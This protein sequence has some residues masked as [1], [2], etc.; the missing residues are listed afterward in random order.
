MGNN[1]PY[2]NMKRLSID[3]EFDC[4]TN[5]KRMNWFLDRNLAVV[6]DDDTYQLTFITKGN[7]NA[8]RSDFYK[9]PL[10]NICVECGT[11]DDL[12]K[13]H[14]VPSQYRK[15]LPIEYKSRSSFDIVIMCDT[16]HN[17]YEL[18]ADKLTKHLIVKNKIVDRSATGG[19]VKRFRSVLR[20]HSD[21][22]PEHRMTQ[23]TNFLIDELNDSIENIMSD[24]YDSLTFPTT[25]ELIMEKVINY[26]DFIITWREHFLEHVDP[27]HI[28]QVWIDDIYTSF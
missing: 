20:N 1:E 12:T 28:S 21:K 17:K 13:H 15:L 5:I 14:V 6:I 4:Y 9:E 16:C 3:G 8:D 23:I 7:G 19:K 18:E 2:E 25:A 22:L 27:Q 26:E 10:E 11:Y 24:K